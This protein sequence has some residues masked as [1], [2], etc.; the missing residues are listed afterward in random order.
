ML[1]DYASLIRPTKYSLQTYRCCPSVGGG[2]IFSDREKLSERSE[3]FSPKKRYPH[4]RTCP[5]NLRLQSGHTPKPQATEDNRPA[6]GR[7]R[8]GHRPSPQGNLGNRM[9]L[10]QLRLQHGNRPSALQSQRDIQMLAGGF[11]GHGGDPEPSD[12]DHLAEPLQGGGFLGHSAVDG[13]AGR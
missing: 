2:G 4:P 6:S 3:F 12:A 10:L 13:V 5:P 8:P 7:T 11:N 1:S 9:K